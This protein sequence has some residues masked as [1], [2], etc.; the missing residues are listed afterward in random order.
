MKK[1]NFIKRNLIVL[2]ICMSVF[3][4]GCNSSNQQSEEVSSSQTQQS[5]SEETYSS[6]TQKSEAI[7]KT[8]I[9]YGDAESFETALNMGKNL[10]GKVVQFTA[11]E[12]HPD[13][14]LG[15][16]IWAGE[17]LNFVSSDNPDVKQGDTLTVKAT[18]IKSTKIGSWII[19]YEKI[20]NAVFVEDTTTSKIMEETKETQ[21]EEKNEPKTTETVTKQEETTSNTENNSEESTYEHNEYYDVVETSSFKNSIGDTILVYKV[22]AKK[23]V[24]ISSSMLAYAED[25]N[26]I[27]KSTDDITLTEGQYNFFRYFFEEDISNATIKTSIKTKNNSFMEGERNAVEMVQYNQSGDNLYI[28]MKQ[29]AD[30]IG[31]F[32]K[33]KLLFYSGDKIVGTENGYFDIYAEN[34]NGK[35]TTDVAE[36]WVYG[37]EFDRIEFIYEP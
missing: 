21:T 29:T 27:G 36:I 12:F 35:D 24:S 3:L 18:K 7:L 28:T 33:F 11:Q 20:D 13:S 17:H 34:L 26:V 22:L 9:D 1:L 10:E 25:G 2:I 16:N 8:T 32:A 30:E 5:E 37:I 19:D 6:Q 15:Y 23:D 31:D 14:V 4:Y